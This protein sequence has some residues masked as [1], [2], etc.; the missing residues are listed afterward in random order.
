MQFLNCANNLK[1][2]GI[3]N[4]VF[5]CFS[6]EKAGDLVYCNQRGIIHC[7]FVNEQCL[8]WSKFRDPAFENAKTYLEDRRGYL[9]SVVNTGGYK[10]CH[11]LDSLDASICEKDCKQL[12]KQEFA[13]N[14]TKNGGL[15]KCCVRRDKRYCHECRQV[16]D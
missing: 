6:V 16:K 7:C 15:F 5:P 8:D 11:P 13:Q 12:S 14:C 2:H 3:S 4:S 9:K 1:E 10:T